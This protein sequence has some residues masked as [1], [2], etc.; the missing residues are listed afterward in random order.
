MKLTAVVWTLAALLFGAS[1]ASA[2]AGG[3]TFDGAP[4]LLRTLQLHVQGQPVTAQVIAVELHIMNHHG[5]QPVGLWEYFY[6]LPDSS[7]G[8]AGVC[9]KWFNQVRSDE[10]GRTQDSTT[11]AWLEIHV[12]DETAFITADEGN[13]LIPDAG[14]RC[15]EALEFRQKVD[16]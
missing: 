9:E 7:T 15:W 3:G 1:H 5:F 6:L 11:L 12:S 4:I 16:Y 14:I 2:S 8:N 10:N 13:R